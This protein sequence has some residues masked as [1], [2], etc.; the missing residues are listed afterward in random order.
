MET[1][2]ALV[3]IILENKESTPQL[4]AILHEYADYIVGRMGIPN[5]KERMS[6]IS[7]V[8]DAPEKVTSA[9]AGKIGMLPHVSVT[10]MYSKKS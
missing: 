7:I 3:G 5:I 8:I 1:R 6:V 2:L 9:L 4:N 10:T